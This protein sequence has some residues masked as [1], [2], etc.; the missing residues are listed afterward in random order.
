MAYIPACAKPVFHVNTKLQLN[1]KMLSMFTYVFE[2]IMLDI[3]VM[4]LLWNI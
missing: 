2:T 3:P 1:I 4:I